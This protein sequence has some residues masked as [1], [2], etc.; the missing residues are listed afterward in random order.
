METCC[1]TT[2]KTAMK[3]PMITHAAVVSWPRVSLGVARATLSQIQRSACL[4]ITGAIRTSPTAALEVI[5]GLLPLDIYIKQVAMTTSNRINSLK[6][7]KRFQNLSSH[8]HILE[9][10]HKE[11]P[12][13]EINVKNLTVK[14]VFNGD[15]AYITQLKQQ[16]SKRWYYFCSTSP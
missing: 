14:T 1:K 4:A 11:V 5:T 2:S 8:S 15:T 3:R 7:W 6:N 12:F 10:T 16:K 9:K 13:T